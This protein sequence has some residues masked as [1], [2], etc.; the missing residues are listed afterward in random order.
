VADHVMG[1]DGALSE[2]NHPAF[3]SM[4]SIE[5]GLER[6]VP[7][8]TDGRL[9]SE[10]I[11]RYIFASRYVEGKTVLDVACGS[12]Y[13]AP[14]IHS[15]GAS[16]YRGIDKS[17]DAI[18]TANERYRCSPT[19][20]FKVGDACR[21]EGI[22]DASID[23]VVSFETIEHLPDPQ[24][25]LAN[26]QRVLAP[27]GI[28]IVSTPNR[29]LFNPLGTLNSKPQN[30]FHVREWTAKE[31]KKLLG[32]YFQVEGVLGQ[33]PRPYVHA[34]WKRL[35]AAVIRE[36]RRSRAI[37]GFTTAYRATKSACRLS[38]QVEEVLDVPVIPVRPWQCQKYT[39]CL[40]RRVMSER[41]AA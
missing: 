6:V 35:K 36:S 1:S 8:E 5:G 10:H 15:A 29:V 38:S 11:S 4:Q 34:L 32:G 27:G 26:I 3:V 37:R 31:F 41:E 14:V 9:Y 30:P 17:M 12:G 16:R 25:F 20:S 28:L 40:C 33:E 2:S 24:S 7:G 19:V 21:L 13:G 22:A 18:Q 23:V 39:V